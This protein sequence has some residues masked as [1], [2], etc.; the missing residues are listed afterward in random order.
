MELFLGE[1]ELIERQVKLAA[2]NVALYSAACPGAGSVNEDSAGL[3]ASTDDAG[4]L[5]VADGVGGERAGKAAS[6]AAV[7]A[8]ADAVQQATGDGLTLRS[9]ILDGFEAANRAVLELGLGAAT[10]L[11]VVEI[12]SGCARPYHTGDS[13]ILIVGQRGKL[14]LLTVA[15]SPVGFAVEAG[16]LDAEE[17]MHHDARH[18]VSN[19]VGS[20][21]MRIE[22]GSAVPL[23]KYDTLVVA[24][25]GLADNLSLD[26]IIAQMRT[27]PLAL[28]LQSLVASCRRRMLDPAAGEPSKP[29]DLTVLAYR[30]A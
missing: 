24:S 23:A 30:R 10:T 4:V 8:V 5:V 18:I 29:D 14:K 21:D 13:A 3:I 15:H 25:D 9:A 26:E 17:A 16:M 27:G 28:S 2:G 1:S 22:I 12:S 7:R 11:A 19:L 20:T 6:N